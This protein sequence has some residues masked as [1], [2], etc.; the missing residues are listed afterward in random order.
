MVVGPWASAHRRSESW[1]GATGTGVCVIVMDGT[2][3]V[4]KKQ[5]L[6]FILLV[7]D[8]NRGNSCG[9]F[10]FSPKPGQTGVAGAYN[11]DVLATFLGAWGDAVTQHHM[12]AHPNDRTQFCPKVG[13]VSVI[14]TMPD[15]LTEACLGLA[16]DCSY[17]LGRQRARGVAEHMAWHSPAAMQVPLQ[18]GVEGE[19]Q[20]EARSWG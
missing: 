10:V 20:H 4:S 2:F 13:C 8:D 15:V 19:A 5:V 6:C 7:D 9:Y 3:G 1:L 18:E 17:G 11:A 12:Q 14:G 16:A